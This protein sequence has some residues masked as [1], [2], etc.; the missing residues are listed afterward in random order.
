M[1]KYRL[2]EALVSYDAFLNKTNESELNINPVNTP[3]TVSDTKVDTAYV[4]N[5]SAEIDTIITGLKDISIQLE[6]EAIEESENQL[7]ESLM[8]TFFDGDPLFP[9]LAGGVAGILSIFGF[10]AKTIIDGKRN[11]KLGAQVEG[12]YN[13]L[14]SLK[15]KKVMLE[16]AADKIKAFQS[17]NKADA[18]DFDDAASKKP[19]NPASKG[20][21]PN[22]DA[23]AAKAKAV[24]RMKAQQLG[25]KLQAVQKKK[26]D[27]AEAI[28]EFQSNLDEKYSKTEL[29]GFFSG[30]VR[31]LI[32][33]KKNE[34]ANTIAKLKLRNLSD[35]L[36]SEEKAEIQDTIDRTGDDMKSGLVSVQSE[37]RENEKKVDDNKD[38][39]IAV[40]DEEIAKLEKSKEGRE[41]KDA[42]VIDMKIIGLKMSK[43]RTEKDIKNLKIFKGKLNDIRK[44]IGELG[45]EEPKKPETTEEPA[46][47]EP[48]AEEPAKEEPTKNAKED[49]LSRVDA[50]IKKEEEKVSK[51]PEAEKIKSKISDL[52]KGIEDL[53]SKEKKDK[54]DQ[55]KIDMINAAISSEKKKLDK[56]TGSEKLSKLKDLKDKISAKES[57]QLEGTELGRIFEM[58]IKRFE[59]MFILNE[60]MSVKDAFSRLI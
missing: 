44:K 3:S 2:N 59:S 14:K 30:K 60:S 38:K 50:L 40:L 21:G 13:N 9:L 7:N 56:A 1:K 20:D 48:K 25:A 39:I 58:E 54:G 43:A 47:E 51:N 17:S 19:A 29:E 31:K 41:G 33:F 45:N 55:D 46:K 11:K 35:S 52:Q 22:V 16:I 10:P 12:D 6:P 49:K 5:L 27:A 34:I 28:E 53:K 32:T 26:E 23:G 57:W 24:A 4:A 18:G 37:D 15:V 8:S 42:L 36:T